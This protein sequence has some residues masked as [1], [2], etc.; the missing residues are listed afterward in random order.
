M[1]YPAEAL[2]L[3]KGLS[4]SSHSAVLAAF[5]REFA[6]SGIVAAKFHRYL[7][8]AEDLRHTSDYD[9]EPPLTA[10]QVTGVLAWAAE[11]LEVAHQI[12]S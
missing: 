10:D 11:F 1:F 4:F 9:I 6:K 3:S 7:L 5:G 8:D 2:L 12:L